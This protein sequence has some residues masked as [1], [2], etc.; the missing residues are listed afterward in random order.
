MQ[1]PDRGSV[2]TLS[3]PSPC[4][5]SF[6]GG[7]NSTAMLIG[8][9]EREARP[10]AILFADTGGEKPET[11]RHVERVNEWCAS[12]G[13]P[14]V[15]RVTYAKGNGCPSLEQ[16]CLDN[17]TLPSKAYGFPGCSVKWKRQP[18]DKWVIDTF[19]DWLGM[20]IKVT[21]LIGIHSGETRRGK[22]PD[23]DNFAFRYPLREWG[24]HQ[25]ECVEAIARAGIPLPVKSA[26]FFCPAMRKVEVLKL[27]REHPELFAR[28]V[29]LEQ[30]AIEAGNLETV[31]GLGRHWTWAALVR[32]DSA[33][34]RLFDDCQAPL[35]DVCFDG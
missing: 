27:S 21:R 6:G 9:K 1:E 13:F 3:Y 24:W 17:E 30:N 11:Y 20:N 2:A 8:L 16:E 25:A 32:A 22:I 5:V 35:C 28:A 18:M 33:Q 7:I 4:V 19:R 31:K 34:L 23:D 14:E 26:C 29:E 10:D 15:V 12:N